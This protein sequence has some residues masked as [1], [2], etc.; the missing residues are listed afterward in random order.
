MLPAVN[1]T[2]SQ[3]TSLSIE[4]TTGEYADLGLQLGDQSGYELSLRNADDLLQ[5]IT[6]ANA[7]VNGQLSALRRRCLRSPPMRK[8]RWR[9]S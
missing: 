9:P 2:E 8:R 3:L 4:S 5:S 1:Q 7:M 6:S